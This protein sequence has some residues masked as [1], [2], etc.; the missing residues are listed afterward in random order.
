MTGQDPSKTGDYE[1]AINALLDGELDQAA[2]A[3]LKARAAEDSQLSQA[4]IDAWQ[5]QRGLDQ[6]QLER[7]PDGL[8]RRLR[9][10]PRQQRAASRGPVFGLPRQALVTGALAM[11]LVAGVIVLTQ[12][13]IR[14]PAAPQQAE[15]Q[16]GTDQARAEQARR[17]LAIAFF[18]LDKAGL[19]VGQ[20]INEALQQEVAEPVKDTLN[21]HLP[22]IGLSRKEKHA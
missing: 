13:V 20:R 17:D 5:L 10:I 8:G 15:N 1:A 9:R 14:S 19:R 4:I 6:L 22:Y 12:P 21:Q 3:E 2:T 11:T 16:S 7:A 18:Y